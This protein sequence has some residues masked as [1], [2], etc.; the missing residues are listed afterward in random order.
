LKDAERYRWLRR[1]PDD[2]KAPRIDVV[3]W[4]EGDMSCNDGTGLRMEKMD[5]TID[6]AMM[7]ANV[8]VS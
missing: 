3:L 7:G 1:Q 5:E 6:K 4:T 8:K 2:T